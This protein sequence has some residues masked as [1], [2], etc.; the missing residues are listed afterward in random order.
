MN[1]PFRAF[2]AAFCI[3]ISIVVV[4][5]ASPTTIGSK[6]S[7]L[8]PGVTTMDE[9]IRLMG[10]PKSRSDMAASG[11]LL[12]WMEMTRGF[13]SAKAA[14]VAVLFDASGKMVRITHEYR[15]DP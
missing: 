5:C 2:S 9:A 4:G 7:Q 10:P 11:V 14:H 3:P 8:R 6:A 1:G 13:A 15:S 12:Q